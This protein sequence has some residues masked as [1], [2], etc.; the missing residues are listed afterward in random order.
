MEN[1]GLVQESE[2]VV[3]SA[4]A[5]MVAIT[6]VEGD[7]EEEEEEEDEVVLK[8]GTSARLLTIKHHTF[9]LEWLSFPALKTGS[10]NFFFFSFLLV[11][12]ES[13]IVLLWKTVFPNLTEKKQANCLAIVYLNSSI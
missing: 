7:G 12:G 2:V 13:A 6:E 5:S 10:V 11:F 8:R 1:E 9:A 3:D 4:A